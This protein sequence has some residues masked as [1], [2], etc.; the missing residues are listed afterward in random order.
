MRRMVMKFFA[1]SVFILSSLS[2]VVF[3]QATG[4]PVMDEFT[5]DDNRLKI[6]F[7]GHGTLMLDFN[8]III[9]VYRVAA[10][11]TAAD[12]PKADIILVTHEH[13]DHLDPALIA[14]LSQDGTQLLA[15]PAVIDKLKKGITLRNGD[16]M[17]HK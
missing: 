7:I 4:N 10:Y 8:G 17:E 2:A 3:G 13:G 11:V 14:R 5:Y 6:H 15:N 9:H 12:A 16:K 1:L